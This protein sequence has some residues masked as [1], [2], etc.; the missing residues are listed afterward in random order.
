M[1][2]RGFTLLEII[3]SISLLAIIAI[4][5]LSSMTFSFARLF[6]TQEMTVDTFSVQQDVEQKIEAASKEDIDYSEDSDDITMNIFGVDIWGHLVQ[7]DVETVGNKYGQI[8]VFVPKYTVV[9]AVPVLGNVAITAYRDDVLIPED[10][11]E[12]MFPLASP[13]D[14]VDGIEI[15]A[16]FVTLEGSEPDISGEDDFL[17]NVYRWYMS[18]VA[19]SVPDKR[20]LIIVKEWNEARTPLSIEDSQDLA[21][22]PNVEEDYDELD[23][24]DFYPDLEGEELCDAI[25]ERFSGRYFYYSVTPY[26]TI[27]RIGVE[28]FSEEIVSANK[29]LSID[30]IY[31]T[32]DVGAEYYPNDFYPTIPADMLNGGQLEVPVKWSPAEIGITNPQ[33]E[34]IASHGTVIGFPDGVDLY[35]TINAVTIES[36]SIPGEPYVGGTAIAEV[37]PAVA[38]ATYQWLISDTETGVFYPI[39]GANGSSY[40]VQSSDLNKFIRVTATGTGG[41]TGTVTSAPKQVVEKTLIPLNSVFIS[42]YPYVG[43]TV[44][45]VVGPSGAT[46]TYQWELSD[47]L[48]GTYSPIAGATGD[49]Y[50]LQISNLDKYIRV[51]ATGTGDYTDTVTSDGIRIAARTLD[52]VSIDGSPYVGETVTADLDPDGATATYQW[53][54]YWNPPGPRWWD[55]YDISGATGS[56]YTLT[57]DD[58]GNPVRVVATGSD[59]WTGTEYSDY[60]SVTERI[61]TS[62]SIV[63]NPYIGETVTADLDPD[64]ATATYQWQRYWNPPGPGGTYWDD[65]DGATGSSYTLTNDDNGNPVRVVATGS[66]GWTGTE[67]SDYISVTKRTYVTGWISASGYTNESSNVNTGDI[68]NAYSSNDSYL[69]LNND[70]D[71]V[72]FTFGSAV[73]SDNL[74]QDATVTGIEVKL[75]G[76]RDGYGY[77]RFEVRLYDDNNDME[78]QS[79]DNLTSSDAEYTLG[80]ADDLWGFSNWDLSELD[81]MRA[82]VQISRD[83]NVYLDHIQI[84]VHYTRE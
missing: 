48:G 82:R 12:S 34:H 36:V 47:T 81:A 20:D 55:W 59:G 4:F 39:S 5:V 35:L 49:A 74:P 45:A 33:E 65:I 73:G 31:V 6:D 54:K 37:D 41:Y 32:I 21:F 62:V 14:E 80:G 56:S 46:A 3:I 69:L 72:Y 38:T 58:N 11:T 19:S 61:L 83:R 15:P 7:E 76:Y 67:Y 40:V 78:T 1:N 16:S 71:R 25:N 26:S 44:E 68:D 77:V 42:G 13:A 70:N 66:D 79:T 30:D 84:Q 50:T 57:N 64:G 23:F 63:G 60:I 28:E 9:Y 10:E 43:E 2:S 22:I 75:E 53:Q 52:S 18:P 17:L 51:S 24:R 29:I 27:G 8:N